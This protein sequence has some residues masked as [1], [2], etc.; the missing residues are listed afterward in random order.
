MCCSSGDFSVSGLSSAK[1]STHQS[2]NKFNKCWDTSSKFLRPR[3][4]CLEH[5]VQIVE[6]LQCKGGANV[7]VICHSGL[8]TDHE[9]VSVIILL[10]FGK[11]KYHIASDV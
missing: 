1:D 8:F 3:I 9:S 11:M 2:L 7:L 4:F 10:K 5:A 6:M